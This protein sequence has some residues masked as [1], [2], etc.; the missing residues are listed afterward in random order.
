MSEV[1]DNQKHPAPADP[2]GPRGHWLWGTMP[3]FRRDT[4]GTLTDCGAWPNPPFTAAT[5]QFREFT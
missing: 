5:C 4:L 2:P 1:V 3:E